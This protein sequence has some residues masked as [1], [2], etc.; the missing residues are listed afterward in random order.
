MER[1][2]LT[3]P[4]KLAN[5]SKLQEGLDS[6]KR[7]CGEC[8]GIGCSTCGDS[9]YEKPPRPIPTQVYTPKTEAL[10]LLRERRVRLEPN[11]IRSAETY[12]LAL[13]NKLERMAKTAGGLA[14]LAFK[15]YDSADSGTSPITSTGSKYS[16]APWIRQAMWD[17]AGQAFMGKQLSLQMHADNYA[18]RLE[19][20]YQAGKNYAIVY[21]IQIGHPVSKSARRHMRTALKLLRGVDECS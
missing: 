11:K 9:G 4:A 7:V 6:R 3:T 12:K 13:S 20:S 8:E 21:V 1:V 5:L 2:S 17:M 19:A 16:A 10:D 15:Q 18:L 14:A